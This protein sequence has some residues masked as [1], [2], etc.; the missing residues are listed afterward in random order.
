MPLSPAPLLPGTSPLPA[1][2]Q[3]PPTR[4]ALRIAVIATLPVLLVLLAVG[5]VLLPRMLFI[6]PGIEAKA[7]GGGSAAA[8][9]GTVFQGFVYPWTRQQTGGGYQTPASLENMKSEADVFHMNAVIIPVIAD[10]PIRS[11]TYILWHSTDKG[12]VDTLPEQDYEKAITDAR[13]AGLVP[14]LELQV[15]Q[16]DNLSNGDTSSELVGNGW[17]NVASNIPVGVEN[18]DGT[19]GN[20]VKVGT[21][22]HNW[23]NNYTDFAVHYAELSQHYHLPYFIMGDDLSG[24]SYDTDQ[25]SRK[26]DPK[27]VENVP[28]E[29]CPSDAGRRECEWR[30]VIHAI[31]SRSYDTFSSHASRI[32]ALYTGK[33][34]YAAGWGSTD[35][36]TPP[37]F[38]KINWW[39]AVDYIG[40]NADFPLTKD[41]AIAGLT[42]LMQAWH[43]VGK[44]TAGQGDIVSKLAAVSNKFG[45]QIVFTSAGYPS[46]LGA[47][48][49]ASLGNSSA[50]DDTQLNATQALISTFSEQTWWAGVF[51]YADYPF[52]PREQQLHW[53]VSSNW[54]GNSLATS[55]KAG[56]W[57][58]TVYKP[59]PIQCS[60]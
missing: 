46:V 57:L 52:A 48:S 7:G 5:Q 31:R 59:M 17:Q 28:G 34:M 25:T 10:M 39:D 26:A 38:E 16:Y 50:D 3:R 41:L 43:G 6:A 30:H 49:A 36:E 22:E 60:C 54:A 20:P 53:N 47:A 11:N 37:A 58:A 12:N 45:R 56:Q 27:G 9:G 21:L 29:T 44:E 15:R 40:V 18:L 8:G 24:L 51:W 14:I 23:F 42:T 32:G 33:L 4:S 1:P 13:K 55:K 2:G 35:G 19:V